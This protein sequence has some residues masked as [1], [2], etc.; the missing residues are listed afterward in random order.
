MLIL[1]PLL[2]DI[3][4][5]RAEDLLAQNY[6][7]VLAAAVAELKV[8]QD[9]FPKD[10]PSEKDHPFTECARFA[11]EIRSPNTTWG[12]WQFP[13]HFIDQPYLDEPGTKIDDFNFE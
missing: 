5:R 6:P 1:I 7:D 12:D 2:I 9:D 4:A 8:L 13:W 10:V 3:V 11:D